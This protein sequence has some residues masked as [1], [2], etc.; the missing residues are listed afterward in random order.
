TV[1]RGVGLQARE[2]KRSVISSNRACSF[3]NDQRTPQLRQFVTKVG[4]SSTDLFKVQLLP[5]LQS[6]GQTT[7]QLGQRGFVTAARFGLLIPRSNSIHC[8][9]TANII[10]WRFLTTRQLS[11]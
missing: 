3:G 8:G 6:I 10:G 1:S 5:A 11:C 4:I 7:N 2:L 9:L